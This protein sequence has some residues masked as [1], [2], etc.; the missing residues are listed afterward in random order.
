MGDTF[1][2]EWQDTVPEEHNGWKLV[3]CDNT[4]WDGNFYYY[5]KKFEINDDARHR[6]YVRSSSQDQMWLNCGVEYNDGLITSSLTRDYDPDFHRSY[7]EFMF[8]DFVQ[9][10]DCAIDM[11]HELDAAMPPVRQKIQAGRWIQSFR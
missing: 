2:D 9:A 8:H 7:E 6:V 5:E 1:Q 4:K 10:L 11:W 3:D